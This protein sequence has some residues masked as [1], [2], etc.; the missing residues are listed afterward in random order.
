MLLPALGIVAFLVSSE[1]AMDSE[2]LSLNY[3]Q[4]I[5]LTGIH[6]RRVHNTRLP[7]I[8]FHQGP[9][10]MLFLR[11]LERFRL[12]RYSVSINHAIGIE[13]I[14]RRFIYILETI[15]RNVVRKIAH[16]HR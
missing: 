12:G 6:I 7:K 13:S 16:R 10:A 1:N 11:E 15:V 5:I 2:R 4:N 14:N 9:I 3:K 8:G